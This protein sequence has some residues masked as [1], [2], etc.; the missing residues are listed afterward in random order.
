[1]AGQLTVLADKTEFLFEFQRE[2]DDDRWSLNSMAFPDAS[3]WN[4]KF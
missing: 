3:G 4:T 1:M 2:R